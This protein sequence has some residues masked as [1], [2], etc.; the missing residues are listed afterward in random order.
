MRVEAFADEVDAASRLVGRRLELLGEL[1]GGEH[2]LTLLVSDGR[3]EYVVRRFPAGDPAVAREAAVYSRLEPESGIVPRLVAYSDE[4]TSPTIVTSR[5]PGGHPAHNLS[6]SAMAS[7]MAGALA[8]IHRLDGDGLPPAPQRPPTGAGPAAAVGR[9]RGPVALSS[10]MSERP[11][12]R[13]SAE[14]KKGG[15][16]VKEDVFEQG[17]AYMGQLPH[18]PGPP[19]V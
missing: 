5:L 12:N 4:P 6:P 15:Y 7:Q 18:A 10:A 1:T 8:R 2:A 17:L 13:T 3:V 11:I 9:V 16:Q 19:T 14:T